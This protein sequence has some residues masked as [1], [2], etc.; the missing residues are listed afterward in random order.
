MNRRETTDRV[1]GVVAAALDHPLDRVTLD[2]SLIDDLGAE[3]IDFLDISFRLETEFGIEIPEDEVWKG[4]FEGV[5]DDP[6]AIAERLAA[7]RRE[8]PDFAW[9]RLP[10]RLT[11]RELPRLIT[12]RTVVEYLERRLGAEPGGT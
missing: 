8:R 5:P 9:E 1:R 4:A 12:V 6:D 7:V 2:A 11:R 3:S 10:S